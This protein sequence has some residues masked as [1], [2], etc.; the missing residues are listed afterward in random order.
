MG[1]WTD[2][3]FSK[4]KTA[5]VSKGGKVKVEKC[6]ACGKGPRQCRCGDVGEAVKTR[7]RT[8]RTHDR[9]DDSGVIWCGVCRSRCNPRNGVCM[10]VTCSSRK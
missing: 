9:R 3:P 1:Y 6:P 4:P 2:K 8:V 7:G 5:T 10:N